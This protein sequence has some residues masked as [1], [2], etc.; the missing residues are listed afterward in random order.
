MVPSGRLTRRWALPHSWDRV[1]RGDQG[2]VAVVL[3]EQDLSEQK[4][5]MI[6]H[7]HPVTLECLLKSCPRTAILR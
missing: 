2:H 3:G 7:F 1:A 5:P 4:D 6:L